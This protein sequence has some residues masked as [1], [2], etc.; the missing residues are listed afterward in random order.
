MT[1]DQ[2]LEIVQDVLKS[3]SG[4]C[5]HVEV[6]V[7]ARTRALTRFADN[8]IHQNVVRRDVEVVTRTISGKRVGLATTN[9]LSDLSGLAALA[10]KSASFLPDNPHITPPVRSPNAHALSR[11]A[12]FD[13]L[14]HNC[15]P[16]RRADAAATMIRACSGA[17]ATASGYVETEGI[18]TAVG[19]DVGTRQSHVESRAGLSL[20]CVSN[21]GS[22]FSQ[23][24]GRIW[25][26]MR[27]DEAARVAIDKAIRSRE[28]AQYPPGEHTVIL[29]PAAVADFL[30][31]LS[32][33]GFG[34]HLQ[35]QRRSW[36]K[37]GE[38]VAGPVSAWADPFD[39]RL[40]GLPFDYEG[41]PRETVV[42]LENGVGRG[43]VSDRMWA[44]R[45]GMENNGHALPLDNSFGPYPKCLRMEA[46][47]EGTLEDL[48]ADTSDAL[49]VTHFWYTNYVNPMRTLVTGTTRDGTFLVEKGMV[50]D[51]VADLRFL[52]SMLDAFSNIDA[53]TKELTLVV[54][55]GVRMLV[56]AVRTK[57][58]FVLDE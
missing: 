4:V 14:A 32:F 11:S 23:Q 18:T 20:T 8:T 34:A 10:A 24:F 6:Q 2:A 25:D 55:F 37:L 29:E 40:A 12:Y 53:A 21:G 54:K 51:A 47:G 43:A 39:P 36:L 48:V 13:P 7:E 38:R 28:P 19:N 56:P 46:N 27:P 50:G 45:A 30:M 41:V 3:A 52:T 1:R 49:L 16:D 35:T 9:D 42:L 44:A 15:P 17:G 57:M 31:F 5:D 22:G 33:L 26:D 58:T